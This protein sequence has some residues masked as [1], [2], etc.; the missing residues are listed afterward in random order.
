[1]N[2]Q[3][4]NTTP[5]EKRNEIWHKVAPDST[6]DYSWSTWEQLP[7]AAQQWI[8]QGLAPCT[9]ENPCASCIAEGLAPARKFYVVSYDDDQQQWFYDYIAAASAVAAKH[10]VLEARSYAVDADAIEVSDLL[11]SAKELNERSIAQI[12]Q[13]WKEQN[14][15]TASG[16]RKG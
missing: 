7:Q 12:E 5:P 16:K 6:D 2:R 1:M 15:E 3:T 13:D 9:I 14:E 8:E 10:A 11:E 4:W